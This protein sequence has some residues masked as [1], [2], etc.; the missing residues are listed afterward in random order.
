I[1]PNLVGL[2]YLST[3]A[4][5]F[6]VRC[7]LGVIKFWRHC[8]A[9][10][11]TSPM[12]QLNLPLEEELTEA[13]QTEAERLV[14][15]AQLDNA[16]RRADATRLATTLAE[17]NRKKPSSSWMGISG[18]TPKGL[19]KTLGVKARKIKVETTMA[20]TTL[21]GLGLDIETKEEG[22]HLFLATARASVD[23]QWVEL[24]FR[25]NGEEIM[26]KI[27]TSCG[28]DTGAT[29]GGNPRKHVTHVATERVCLVFAFMIGRLINVGVV[30]RD[31]LSQ[32]MVKKGHR[33]SF[34]DFRTR[35]LRVQQ[36]EEV[37]VDYKSRY[38]TKG[39]DVTKKIEPNG[40]GG[41]VLSI[42][43]GPMTDGTT[44]SREV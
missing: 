42:C 18:P 27:P 40:L 32:V 24:K 20:I 11:I 5:Y 34:C 17:H 43:A 19:T 44:R 9:V 16:A 6:S 22:G 37:E 2:L 13:H 14:E 33:F 25:L 4:V 10:S 31:V 8:R 7:N 12:A 1:D 3:T 21:K 23:V 35:F 26:L 38:D 28:D 41:A 39:L 36:V 29:L 15:V 30:I